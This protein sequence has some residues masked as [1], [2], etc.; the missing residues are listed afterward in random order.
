MT[1][2]SQLTEGESEMVD[3]QLEREVKEAIEVHLRTVGPCK[4][5]ALQGRFPSISRATFWRYVR[6]VRDAVEDEQQADADADQA[7][8]PPY[9]PAFEK[10]LQK[11]ERDAEARRTGTVP[12]PRQLEQIQALVAD[13]EKL[14]RSCLDR[15]GNIRNAALFHK[16]IA[17]GLK[18]V[19]CEFR[20]RE[21][22]VEVDKMLG[23]NQAVFAVINEA[24]PDVAKDIFIRLRTLTTKHF[25]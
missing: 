23:F 25:G 17:L 24:A 18:A 3:S 8:A 22:M 12:V 21:R 1:V 14:K 20:F 10:M 15:S 7:E 19:E 2:S 11:M 6:T 4:W 13:S 16:S 5:A 9:M